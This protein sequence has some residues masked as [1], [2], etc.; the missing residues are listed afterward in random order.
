MRLLGN[1]DCSEPQAK[2]ILFFLD[3]CLPWRIAEYL[4]GVSYPIT[5]W[6]REFLGQQGTKDD[7]LIRHLGE[8][9]LTWITKDDEAK[10][11]HE[12]AIRKAQISVIWLSRVDPHKEGQASQEQNQHQRHPPHVD[13]QA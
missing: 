2:Q 12:R 7:P 1:D 5:S 10:S 4:D 13:G 9:G 11:E 8:R 6:H 3:E